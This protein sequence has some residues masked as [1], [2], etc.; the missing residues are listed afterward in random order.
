MSY[1]LSA[2]F[3]VNEKE[4]LV[5]I[6]AVSFFIYASLATTYWIYKADGPLE[7]TILKST[8]IVCAF[9]S[10]V[11]TLQTHYRQESVEVASSSISI[12][13]TR[14]GAHTKYLSSAEAPGSER[15]CCG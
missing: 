10:L 4:I 3:D 11:F 7:W 2:P 8:V 6:H 13:F 1:L 9:A 15:R 14:A 12:L 5:R